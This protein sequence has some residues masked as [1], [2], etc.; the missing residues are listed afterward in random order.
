MEN[1]NAKIVVMA[2][3]S[4]VIAVLALSSCAEYGG[5]SGSTVSGPT[6]PGT[7]DP[8]PTTEPDPV[9]EPEPEPPNTCD[10]DQCDEV[11]Y[12]SKCECERNCRYGNDNYECRE[13]RDCHESCELAFGWC[14]CSCEAECGS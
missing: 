3:I 4:T 12:E 5:H 13:D 9:P 10:R 11:C 1:V 6:V 2:I 14:E 8:G 7:T